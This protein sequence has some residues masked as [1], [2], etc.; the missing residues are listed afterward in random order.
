MVQTR[1][2]NLKCFNWFQASPD[3]L[4]ILLI[5]L[6]LED[7]KKSYVT[8]P[9]LGYTCS[10]QKMWAGYWS[11]KM[12]WILD[13]S[14][15]VWNNSYSSPVPSIPRNPHGDLMPW[16]LMLAFLHA[17][18]HCQLHLGSTSCQYAQRSQRRAK[19]MCCK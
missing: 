15:L 4:S 6:M 18:S 8:F 14:G 13:L 9:F 3:P 12:R 10:P 7:F 17:S 16:D 11:S 5:H 2:L 19:L 1:A